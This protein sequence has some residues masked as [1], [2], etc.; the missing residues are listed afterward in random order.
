MPNVQAYAEQ[1]WSKGP[2]HACSWSVDSRVLTLAPE[3]LG[4]FIT[5]GK[6][7]RGRGVQQYGFWVAL[8]AGF[9]VN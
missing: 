8:S 4:L 7:G 5:P 2:G 6:I 9:M 1:L 3:M